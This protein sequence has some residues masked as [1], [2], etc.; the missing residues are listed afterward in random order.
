MTHWDVLFH[1]SYLKKWIL[2]FNL[3][4]LISTSFR[5]FHGTFCNSQQRGKQ[6]RRNHSLGL[7]IS[8]NLHVLIFI[9]LRYLCIEWVRGASLM[10]RLIVPPAFNII[11]HSI[12]LDQLSVLGHWLTAILFQLDWPLW[13]YQVGRLLLCICMKPLW[14]NIW[15]CGLS[16]Y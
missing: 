13:E 6:Q 11:S 8:T 1:K 5:S 3:S 14:E 12:F 2:I 10:I 16:F 7:S 9:P 4:F 15:G